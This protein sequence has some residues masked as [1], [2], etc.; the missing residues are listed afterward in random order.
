MIPR[1]TAATGLALLAFFG[2]GHD[3]FDGRYR[4]TVRRGLEFL[5]SVQKPDGD[6][7]LPSEA[8]LPFADTIEAAAELNIRTIVQP[9]GSKNDEAV[10][11]ACDGAGITMIFTGTRHF[12]H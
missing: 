1:D 4:D 3:H 7:F 12:K 5:I 9:G 2:A 6:L 11:A 10:I 8:F